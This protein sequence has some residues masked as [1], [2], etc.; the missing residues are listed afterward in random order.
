[1]EEIQAMTSKET[2]R[3]TRMLQWS[4]YSQSGVHAQDLDSY[5]EHK[6]LLLQ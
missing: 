1:V 4:H 6:A 2:I 3:L 5:C